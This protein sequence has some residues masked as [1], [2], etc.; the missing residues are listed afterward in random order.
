VL[1]VAGS[2]PGGDLATVERYDPATNVWS[3][4]GRLPRPRSAHTATLLP[5]G[6]V[7][8]VGGRN[9]GPELP[10]LPTADLYDPAE[11]R[12]SSAPGLLP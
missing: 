2:G 11:N 3:P 10:F 4:A 8:V 6:Q 5:S 12:W 7:L 9:D 1:V